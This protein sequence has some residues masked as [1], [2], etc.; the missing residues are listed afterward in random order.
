MSQPPQHT[1]YGTSERCW[2]GHAPVYALEPPLQGW[3]HY[4]PTC[5]AMVMTLAEFAHSRAEPLPDGAIGRVTA[6][7]L[8]EPL[9]IEPWDGKQP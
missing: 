4:C 8:S 2:R 5:V 9:R 7:P 3:T 6:L 1:V